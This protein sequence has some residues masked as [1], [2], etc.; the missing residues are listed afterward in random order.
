MVLKGDESAP[1][2]NALSYYNL[3]DE[4]TK[5]TCYFRVTN[6]GVID[7]VSTDF[8]LYLTSTATA[9]SANLVKRTPMYGYAG[10]DQTNGIADAEKIY[11][12]SS[13]G[14]YAILNIPGLD[15]LPNCI[16]H[17]AEI[18][19]EPLLLTGSEIYTSPDLLFLDLVD[20]ANN[21]FVT[22]ADDFNYSTA[23]QSY[24]YR[25]FGGYVK[26]AKYFINL[27]RYVQKK[28]TTQSKN[29][30]LRL[31]A[32]KDAYAYY[33][34][35]KESGSGITTGRA[36]FSINSQIAKGR[37]VI[38]GGSHPSQPMRLRIIYSKI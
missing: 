9:Y 12:Q 10:L 17:R 7:T 16:I 19:F 13:P 6:N 22:V 30:A 1:Q 26:D 34:F 8:T 23:T 24:D 11:L 32:P 37:V 15:T 36:M 38:G 27:T 25:Y 4:N 2:Q 14:S 5:L 3:Y 31:Y 29:Y 28:V 21:R 18:A 33:A 20:S 35:P